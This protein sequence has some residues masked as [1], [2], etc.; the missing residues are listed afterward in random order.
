VKLLHEI[1][2]SVQS[3]TATGPL[4]LTVGVKALNEEEH[5]GSCLA[6]ALSVVRRYGGQVVLADSGSTDATVAIARQ[7]D[8]RILQLADA[9]DS[10][11]G[12]GAQ[13]AY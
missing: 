1:D 13:L 2:A 9:A 11:C 10:S 7:V 6:S 12:A 3:V 5:I 4:K 8:V